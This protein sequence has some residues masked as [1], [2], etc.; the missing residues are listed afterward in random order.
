MLHKILDHSVTQKIFGSIPTECYGECAK[1]L[2][3]N[4]SN[5]MTYAN[6]A[7]PD[8][9]ALK[10]QSDQSLHCL[11]FHQVFCEINALKKNVDK[12]TST[13]KVFEILGHLPYL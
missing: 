12:K 1:I 13:H 8:Q 11:P 9:T 7:D 6:S 5:D 3:T 4:L 10:E 2:Y